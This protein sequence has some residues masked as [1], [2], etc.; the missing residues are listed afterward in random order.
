MVVVVDAAVVDPVTE[1]VVDV[2]R[3]TNNQLINHLLEQ[4][5]LFPN[6]DEN[7]YALLQL[8]RGSGGFSQDHQRNGNTSCHSSQQQ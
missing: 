2:A 3:I 4:L 1:G 6:A 7:E 8:T 5:S